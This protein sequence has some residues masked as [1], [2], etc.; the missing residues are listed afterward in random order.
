MALVFDNIVY[1]LQRAGGISRFWSKITAPYLESAHFIEQQ[2]AERNIFRQEQRIR[3]IDPDHRL[4]E[5]IARYLNFN[6]PGSKSGRFVFHSS[7]YRINK[8]PGC[9]NVTTIHDLIYEKFGEGVGARLHLWQ[10]ARALRS[11]DCIVC[12]SRHTRDDLLEHYPFCAEI[13]LHVIPNGVSPI[14]AELRAL[15]PDELPS[16]LGGRRYF[17]Y[18]GNRGACKGFERIHAALRLAPDLCCAVVGDPFDAAE[19]SAIG[20][21]GDAGR[22]LNVG[23][24]SDR[25]LRTLYAH[26]HFFFFPSLY[27][28]FGIPPLE[29]MQ[30][31]CPVIASDRSS[32][33]EIVGSAALLFD[34]DDPA[35]LRHA[36]ERLATPGTRDALVE[37]GRSR[38]REFSWDAAVNAYARLYEQLLSEA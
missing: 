7:Y 13:P 15:S 3:H 26:A 5:R 33:P 30:M 27:E 23:K 6:R 21:K 22:I 29:A 14:D 36:L 2:G 17:L 34:P 19:L 20:A 24:V 25:T 10:K 38:V 11:S 4:P 12:V 18:V 9:V 28:G 32:I 31:D 1:K 8:A 37:T 35:S 16:P